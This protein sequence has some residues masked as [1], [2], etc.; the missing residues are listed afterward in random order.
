MRYGTRSVFVALCLLIP[1]AAISASGSKESSS[2]T[3]AGR[4]VNLVGYLLGDPPAGMP[5]VL[6]ALNAK[7]KADLN[8]TTQINYIGWGDLQAKYPLVLAAGENIDWIYTA[9][10]CFYFQQA[11]RGAFYELS[12]AMLQKDMP[13]HSKSLP[14]AGW[15]QA[16]LPD[17]KL[18]MIPTATP[19]RKVPVAVIR[20][21]LRKKYGVPPVTKLADIEPYLKAIKDNEPSMIPMD[22]DS[23]YDIGRPF[24][25]LAYEHGP[26]IED[27][28]FTT[29]GGSGLD[30][31]LTPG[32]TK[33]HY[34]L[35]EPILSW[36]RSAAQTMK[37]WYDAG[38]IN[39][40]VFANKVRSKESFVQGKSA[41][42]FGNSV[43]IQSTI[44][45]ATANG[46][47]VE[48]IPEVDGNG[49]FRA[50]P[51]INNGVGLAAST[52]NA[53]KTLQM[54]DLIMENKA[55]DFLVYFGIEGKNYIMTS[56]G[57]VGLPPGL[58]A[59]KNTYPPDV[60]GFWFTNKDLFPPMA[61]WTPAYAQHR[62]DIVDKH[63]LVTT[64]WVSFS[65]VV[66]QIKTEV[67]NCNQTIIQYAQPMWIGAVPDVNQALATLDG[68]LKAAGIDRIREVLQPQVDTYMKRFQ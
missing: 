25:D 58:A 43:D 52:K 67:A 49:H 63:Y 13:L 62:K 31:L 42:G 17:G 39:K 16:R 68:K 24:A 30:W 57:K 1:L 6:A 40:D 56:D 41:V 64:P 8:V 19:D 23:Q 50:D 46:W 14:K 3:Q 47:D 34:L 55:Y 51:F 9:N 18:Y 53:D 59:D 66:D 32:D 61:S 20:G 54:L 60:S 10:W 27:I 12:D 44:S 11:A 15:D 37:R 4:Q 45:G 7:L 38:Y 26:Y 36:E 5:D 21:D 48:L 28:L 2:T 33:L 29:G 35:D 22:L 65:P